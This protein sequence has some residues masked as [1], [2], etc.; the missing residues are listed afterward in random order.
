M[1]VEIAR[2]RARVADGRGYI[3]WRRDSLFLDDAPRYAGLEVKDGDVELLVLR[4]SDIL[5]KIG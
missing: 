5:V 3:V 1:S 4:E 2:R